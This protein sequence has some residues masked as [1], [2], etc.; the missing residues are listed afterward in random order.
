ML[1]YGKWLGF[2]AVAGVV[3][4]LYRSLDPAKGEYWSLVYVRDDETIQME[5]TWRD[6]PLYAYVSVD[7]CCGTMSAEDIMEEKEKEGKP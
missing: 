3:N 7:I 1:W 4:R 6:S 5:G 2:D